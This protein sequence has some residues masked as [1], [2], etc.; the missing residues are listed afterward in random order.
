MDPLAPEFS[1]DDDGWVNLYDMFFYPIIILAGI[2]YILAMLGTVIGFLRYLKCHDPRVLFFACLSAVGLL[3]PVPF[4][5][6]IGCVG[7]L[8]SS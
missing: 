2:N 5:G 7:V 3:I 1:N 8:T 6:I 4:L